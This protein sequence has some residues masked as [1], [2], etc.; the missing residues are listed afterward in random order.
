VPDNPKPV[1]G[2]DFG[3]D[4]LMQHWK[5][6]LHLRSA[7]AAASASGR[8]EVIAI[9]ETLEAKL[10]GYKPTVSVSFPEILV[11]AALVEK[12]DKD[13]DGDIIIAVT[14][15]F[16]RFL[17]EL[18]RDPNALYQ[19]DS[20]QFEELIAGAYEEYGCEEVILTPRSGDRGRDVIATS[21]MF[22]TV[23]ILDQVK[24]YASHRV[25]EADDVRA[26]YGVVARDQGASKGIVTTTSIF[27]PGVYEEFKGLIPG[28][29]S[30]R[31]GV[32]LK[33]WLHV[34]NPDARHRGESSAQNN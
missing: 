2:G 11:G 5:R 4:A 10:I 1:V 28:R 30:L 20:R 15:M 19:L 22:G 13:P 3:T 12:G 7:S 24:L 27:A 25:V 33:Q 21:R 6:Q 32:A 8:Y 17:R 26:L 18:E 34:L 14:P 23:R 16:R 29:I 31:D 9:S